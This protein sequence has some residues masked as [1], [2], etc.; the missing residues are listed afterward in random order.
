[1]NLEDVYNQFPSKKDC[2]DHLE[3]LMW[4]NNP[5][6]P[7]CASNHFTSSQEENRYHCNTCNTSYSVT[8]GTLFH[9]TKID[10]QKWFYA[11]HLITEPDSKLTTREFA[12][13]INTTKDTAWRI[14]NEIKNSMIKQEDIIHKILKDE[15]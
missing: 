6:C 2:V 13:K 9:K 12:K 10:L 3:T 15:Q 1:M 11:I 14:M 7:Y 5:I 8:V 4:N